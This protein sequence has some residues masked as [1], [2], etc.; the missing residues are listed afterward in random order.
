MPARGTLGDGCD[1]PPAQ[2]S[3]PF[4]T[5]DQA[6]TIDAA[7]AAIERSHTACR[8]PAEAAELARIGA[9]LVALLEANAAAYHQARRQVTSRRADQ[10]QTDRARDEADYDRHL[11][12]GLRVPCPQ[13]GA[14][15]GE[16]CHGPKGR[17]SGIH[18][19]RAD[20]AAWPSDDETAPR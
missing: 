3:L 12:G 4:L 19:W 9:D 1:N 18:A 13:C 5:A 2:L 11:A 17:P 10:R 14:A 6:A 20:E 16:Q 15:P 7:R 8:R